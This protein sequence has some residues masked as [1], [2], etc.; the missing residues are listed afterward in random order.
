MERFKFSGL[1]KIQAEL[2]ERGARVSGV[3]NHALYAGAKVMKQE[4]AQAMKDYKLKDTGDLIKSIKSENP[5]D[6]YREN[7]NSRAGRSRPK[8]RSQYGKSRNSTIWKFQRTRPPV[9]YPCKG[10][11]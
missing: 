3:V 7:D 5:K 1:D 2:E 9:G 6:R 4:Q 10:T 11:G 8:R